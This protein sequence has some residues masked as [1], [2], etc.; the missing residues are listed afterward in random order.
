MSKQGYVICYAGRKG[1]KEM[2]LE[3][4]AS[5]HLKTKFIYGIPCLY[6]ESPR[7]E[8]YAMELN[9][10]KSSFAFDIKLTPIV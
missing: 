6:G 4:I 7:T 3:S 8:I 1:E 9:T 2:E 10:S 5:S